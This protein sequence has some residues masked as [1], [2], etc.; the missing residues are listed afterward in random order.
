MIYSTDSQPVTQHTD[1]HFVTDSTGYCPDF[2]RFMLSRAE[3][4]RA[5]TATSATTARRSS[6]PKKAVQST[7]DASMHFA[8][9]DAARVFYLGRKSD[10]IA[11]AS[12]A[13]P[14]KIVMI[15]D[16]PHV[17][18]DGRYVP[19]VMKKSSEPLVSAEPGVAEMYQLFMLADEDSGA[20]EMYAELLSIAKVLS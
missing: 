8:A 20:F 3:R 6:K 18:K 13:E 19:M 2:D 11:S 16:I 1:S 9:T 17:K 7:V 10:F 14:V 12:P 15:N 4:N 5:R